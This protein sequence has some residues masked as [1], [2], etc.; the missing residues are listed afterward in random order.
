MPRKIL[1]GQSRGGWSLAAEFGGGGCESGAISA[2]SRG[3]AK[4]SAGVGER[5]GE[6]GGAG[7]AY[8]KFFIG[9]VNSVGS[10]GRP[11]FKAGDLSV[12]AGGGS[13]FQ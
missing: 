6:G 11:L 10:D 13:R 5:G 9:G 7:R 1:V 2:I 4:A 3:D 8:L 12:S